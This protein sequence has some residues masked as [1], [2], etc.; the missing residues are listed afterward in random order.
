[1]SGIVVHIERGN[2]TLLRNVV[3]DPLD[4]RSAQ[5]SKTIAPGPPLQWFIPDTTAEMLSCEWVLVQ[6]Q[7][8]TAALKSMESRH[9]ERITS[10]RK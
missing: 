2:D 3:F 8:M 6:V 10:P 7:P 9:E 4:E 5:M 1:L